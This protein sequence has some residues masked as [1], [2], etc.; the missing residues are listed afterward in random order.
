[1]DKSEPTVAELP[2]LWENRQKYDGYDLVVSRD[3]MR[4][5]SDLRAAPAREAEREPTEAE[6]E[7]GRLAIAALGGCA[8]QPCNPGENCDCR[9]DARAS[10]IALRRGG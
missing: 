1:M 8:T 4:C 6:I 7:R 10:I 5:A 9:A 2:D 3:N